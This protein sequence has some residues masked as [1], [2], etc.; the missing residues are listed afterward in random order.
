MCRKRRVRPLLGKYNT[1]SSRQ[2]DKVLTRADRAIQAGLGIRR[3]SFSPP[4]IAPRRLL[5]H[6]HDPHPHDRQVCPPRFGG[7][8]HV[9]VHSFIVQKQ[10]QSLWQLCG[11]PSRWSVAM[12]PPLAACIRV[13]RL[14]RSKFVVMFSRAVDLPRHFLFWAVDQVSPCEFYLLLNG[15]DVVLSFVLNMVHC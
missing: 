13:V 6:T 3:W 8:S 10:P 12:L 5:T 11:C 4:T 15:N 2:S 7:L 1:L 14:I 9:L